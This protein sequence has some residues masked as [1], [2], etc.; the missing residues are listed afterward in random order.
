MDFREI[1]R[2]PEADAPGDAIFYTSQLKARRGMLSSIRR[3][4]KPQ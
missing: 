3:T 1:K 2:K 4:G